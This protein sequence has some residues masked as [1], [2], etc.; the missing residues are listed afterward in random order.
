[1]KTSNTNESSFLMV[2]DNRQ[3]IVLTKTIVPGHPSEQNSLQY[4]KQMRMKK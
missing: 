3:A 4:K 2:N 1:M